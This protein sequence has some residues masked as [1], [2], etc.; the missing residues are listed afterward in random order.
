MSTTMIRQLLHW[1]GSGEPPPCDARV[2]EHGAQVGVYAPWGR[3]WEIE[4]TI[5]RVSSETK[6]LTDWHFYAGRVSVVTLNATDV[7]RVATCL[8]A[9]VTD[10][11]RI[12]A[13]RL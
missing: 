13:V 12:V 9:L 6:T 1:W 8:G 2:F 3:S 11:K 5:R 7:E 4:K 10:A